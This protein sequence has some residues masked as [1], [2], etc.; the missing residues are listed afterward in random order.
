M[1]QAPETW[2]LAY[3]ALIFKAEEGEVYEPPSSKLLQKRLGI[4]L[5]S[6]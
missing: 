5:D 1:A 4:S 3:A 2:R 6:L